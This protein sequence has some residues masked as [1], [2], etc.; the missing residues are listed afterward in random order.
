MGD[1]IT[2][3]VGILDSLA[4][5]RCLWQFWESE[6]EVI[7]TDVITGGQTHITDRSR[8]NHGLHNQF[9]KALSLLGCAILFLPGGH[10]SSNLNP[11][12][13]VDVYLMSEARAVHVA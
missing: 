1:W 9:H 3:W 12:A 5:S 7:N 2:L 13:S 8:S 4:F 10:S 6:S 11:Q